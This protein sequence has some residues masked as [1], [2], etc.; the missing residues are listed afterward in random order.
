MP[1]VC[2]D[3]NFVI[4]GF[5]RDAT[6]GQEAN[7]PRVHH[8]LNTFTEKKD[9]V[10]IPSL[11]LAEVLLGFP[12][13]RRDEFTRSLRSQVVIMP[14]DVKAASHFARLMDSRS[15]ASPLPDG[16]TR[17]ML[18]TDRMIAAVAIANQ[19]D[20]IYSNDKNLKQ[21]VEKV[22]PVL[23]TDDIPLPPQQI[24]LLSD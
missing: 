16:Y 4:W 14:F 17:Q 8:L 19:C 10:I 9:I 1:T 13:E 21:F 6:P 18:K 12:P 23:T 24:P 2:F 7:I 22:I 5:K 11:V 20:C 15:M 3:T